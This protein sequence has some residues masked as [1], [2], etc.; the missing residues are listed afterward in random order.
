MLSEKE[1]EMRCWRWRQIVNIFHPSS[2]HRAENFFL[3]L[4][5]VGTT[6]WQHGIYELAVPLNQMINERKLLLL[7]YAKSSSSSW[8]WSR[9]SS[10]LIHMY[11]T[12]FHIFH[13]KNV[14]ISSNVRQTMRKLLF[15]CSLQPY[16][17]SWEFWVIHWRIKLTSF[18]HSTPSTE[19]LIFI[20]AYAYASSVVDDD[21]TTQLQYT[22]LSL[23]R[24][25][26]TC[27]N[28]NKFQ[29]K[30]HF[31][32]AWTSSFWTLQSLQQWIFNF[33]QPTTQ[34]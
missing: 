7:I 6:T 19:L 23:V 20:N 2:S 25:A 16:S 18:C 27:L 10:D 32:R 11:I 26:R 29:L 14:A 15:L 4:P 9:K 8:R 13:D 21:N 3:P 34:T 17:D 28:V 5:L 33:P 24:V 30:I 1:R 12:L 31:I 22:K